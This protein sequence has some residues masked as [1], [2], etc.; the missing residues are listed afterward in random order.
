[1]IELGPIIPISNLLYVHFDS[2]LGFDCTTFEQAIFEQVDVSAI[3]HFTTLFQMSLA[4]V[5]L[6]QMS[7]AEVSGTPLPSRVIKSCN[8]FLQ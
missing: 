5:S 2:L 1:M 8:C 6:A 7:L 4:Q 3:Q